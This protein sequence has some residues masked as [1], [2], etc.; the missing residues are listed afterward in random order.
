MSKFH[1]TVVTIAAFASVACSTSAPS[2]AADTASPA[3]VAGRLEEHG[4]LELLNVTATPT[5]DALT[6]R[7]TVRNPYDQPI[8]GIRLVMQVR[9]DPTLDAPE[10]ARSQR[11]MDAKLAPGDHVP[12]EIAVKIVPESLAHPGFLLQAFASSRAGEKLPTP[13]IWRE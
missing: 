13:P 8:E 6:F 4:E 1:R 5:V 2:P 12:F 3:G 7:G 10:L 11:V 9:S